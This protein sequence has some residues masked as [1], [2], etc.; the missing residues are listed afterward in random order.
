MEAEFYALAEGLRVASIHS[1][2]R[3]SC[4][5]YVDVKP[6]VSKIDGSQRCVDKW[7]DYR[8]SSLWLLNKFDDWELHHCPRE[9]N[10]DAHELARTALFRGRDGKS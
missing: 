1:E 6:L 9:H 8:A 2:S 5:A 3:E 7:E 10:E 4:E